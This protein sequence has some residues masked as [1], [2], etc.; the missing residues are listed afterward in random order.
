MFQGVECWF[1]N[2]AVDHVDDRRYVVCEEDV[3]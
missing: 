2:D 1:D 3:I